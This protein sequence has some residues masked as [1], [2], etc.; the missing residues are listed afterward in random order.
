[1]HQ[2]SEPQGQTLADLPPDRIE[3]GSPPFYNTGV[4]YFGP[5]TVK[6]PRSKVGMHI[7]LLVYSRS[8]SG[9]ITIDG[10]R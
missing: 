10:N 1:M 8:P 2:M 9:G 3:I 6:I 5:K 4:D 7:Y